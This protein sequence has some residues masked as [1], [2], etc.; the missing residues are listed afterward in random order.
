[1]A[2]NQVVRAVDTRLA[3]RAH[4]HVEAV[5]ARTSPKQPLHPLARIRQGQSRW[6]STARTAF[7]HFTTESA[8]GRAYPNAA[9]F[10]KT[11]VATALRQASGRAPFASTLRPNLTGGTLGRTAGGYTLGSGRVG[12]ARYFS[13][14]PASQAQVVQNV[15]Q[16]MRAFCLNGHKAQFDGYSSRTGEKRFRTVSTL[17]DKT[18]RTMQS[19]S[20]TTPGSWVDFR[21]NPTIT[22]LTPLTAFNINDSL[23]SIKP[24]INS[25]GLIDVLSADFS[26]ALKDLAAVLNDVKRFADLGDLPIS[27]QG[28][29][30]RIHFPGC[31]A[32]T[33]QC[34]CEELGIQR[35]MVSQ[36]PA[37]DE[38]VGAELALLFPYAPETASD[39]DGRNFYYMAAP[40]EHSPLFTPEQSNCEHYSTNSTFSELSAEEASTSYD[41]SAVRS[42]HTASIADSEERYSPLEYQ[43]IEG[44]Y[45]FLEQ[46]DSARVRRWHG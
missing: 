22:A 19:V 8:H 35:G 36:D 3:G 15:S 33:V 39:D 21:I 28:S 26:R 11:R 44:I 9:A 29:K 24:H 25:E 32:D 6:F 17:Q 2:W 1:M 46:C 38:F 13:H 45:R 18:T 37:F 12:G 14:G 40:R 27:L 5:L 41:R 10:S 16:A 4:P 30:I 34:L 43:G 7:R 42:V 31:D 23:S 20:R